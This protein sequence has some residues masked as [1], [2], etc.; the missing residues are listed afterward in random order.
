M[1][2]YNQ[3]QAMARPGHTLGLLLLAFDMEKYDL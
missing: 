2:E 1:V 3:V